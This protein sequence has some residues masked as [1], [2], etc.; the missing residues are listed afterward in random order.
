V[1]KVSK[2]EKLKAAKRGLLYGDFKLGKTTLACGAPDPVVLSG[3]GGEGEIECTRIVFEEVKR[4]G[5]TIERHIPRSSAEVVDKINEIR[6]DGLPGQTLILDG[7]GSIEKLF[8]ASIVGVEKDEKGRLIP[9]LN[10]N[11][12]MGDEM[13]LNRMREFVSA[14]E[15][16]WNEQRVNIILVCHERMTKGGDE[17]GE[18]KY[19]G[20]ALNA[21]SK[22]NVAGFIAGWVDWIGYLQMEE[23]DIKI[24]ETANGAVMKRKPTG[25]RLLHMRPSDAFVAGFRGDGPDATIVLPPTAPTIAHPTANPSS[26]WRAFWSQ[27]EA[28]PLDAAKIRGEFDALLA[29][30]PE[31]EVDKR[32]KLI[33][34]RDGENGTR[35]MWQLIGKK[36]AEPPATASAPVKAA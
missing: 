26:P 4:N 10:W 8:A 29:L 14:L 11:F 30:V 24:G 25:R 9:S 34:I 35:A 12:G 22:G 13:L 1:I 33:A 31:T 5:R 6:R 19:M 3:E 16:I 18:F 21:T 36:K 27:V 20:P 15:A 32:A 7:F 17:R 28:G 23:T 2:K